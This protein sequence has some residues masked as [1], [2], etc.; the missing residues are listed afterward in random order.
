MLSSSCPLSMSGIASSTLL[1][2]S[3]NGGGI[4]TSFGTF[5]LCNF[6]DPGGGFIGCLG[7]NPGKLARR[8]L[9][10]PL[11]RSGR[12]AAR[13]TEEGDVGKLGLRGGAGRE[14]RLREPS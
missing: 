12:V 7:R 14:A 5:P 11:G 4:K 1:N 2:P 3:G 13:E 8:E 10:P 9:M 6:A